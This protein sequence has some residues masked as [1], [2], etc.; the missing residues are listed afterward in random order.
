MID[1]AAGSVLAES[2]DRPLPLPAAGELRARGDKVRETPGWWTLKFSL[3]ALL[4]RATPGGVS[5]IWRSV[6]PRRQPMPGNSTGGYIVIAYTYGI[7]TSAHMVHAPDDVHVAA[8]RT[9]LSRY[10]QLEASRENYQPATLE[11]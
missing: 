8:F 10:C 3:D 11:D 9:L 5:R 6:R 2:Q 7:F 4:D 1:A